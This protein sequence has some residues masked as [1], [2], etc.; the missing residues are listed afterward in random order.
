MEQGG[1]VFGGQIELTLV[2]HINTV[3]C[4]GGLFGTDFPA[5]VVP[6]QV[7]EKI[8]LVGLRTLADGAARVVGRVGLESGKKDGGFCKSTI[9]I[10]PPRPDKV[11]THI[12]G[13]V[14]RDFGSKKLKAS[15]LS[16]LAGYFP[17]FLSA[18]FIRTAGA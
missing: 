6:K 13:I 1:V 9:V 4:Q 11:R 2:G 12:R 18:N 3:Q 8:D 7:I 17:F 15:K 10:F 14:Y 16:E 5:L